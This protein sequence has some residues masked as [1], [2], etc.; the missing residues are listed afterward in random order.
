MQS[1]LFFLLALTLLV[2]IHEYGHFWVA[3]RCGVKV[4]KFSVG[5][6]KPLWQK[7]GR[8][9]TL[10]VLA[11]IPLGGYVKMLD[12]REGEVPV[13]QLEQAFNR[14]SLRARIAIVSAGPIANILFAIFAYWLIFV[15]GIPGL[16]PII[17]EVTI[18]SPAE[19]AQFVSGAEI[20]TVNSYHTPTWAAV[21]K[22]LFMVAN[23]GGTADIDIDMG[24]LHQQR[25]LKVPKLDP[26]AS[27]SLLQ[28]LGILPFQPKLKPV[29]GVITK[30]G[31]ANK[32][33]LQTGDILL[34]A[35]GQLIDNWA[36]WVE[37]IR[38][39]PE[40]SLTITINRAGQ[41]L[42][43]LMTPIKTKENVGLIGA[44][45]DASKTKIPDELQAELRFGPI[46]AIWQA[47]QATWQFSSSSIKSLIGML[48]GAVSTTNLG[49]PISIAQFAGASAQ[50]GVI[51]FIGFL[52]MI[53]ISLGIL[54][55][56]PIPVL[57]GGHLM[58]FFIEGI[59]GKPLSE[60]SQLLAQKIG[61]I[62]LLALM[63]IAFFNDLSRLFG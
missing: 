53:S 48:T 39:S 35:N 29:I 55:L 45:V 43:L 31:A 3:R 24:G 19:S 37:L 27:T 57:D 11:A 56:L 26:Q 6:G 62:L 49:G 36:G 12:E 23:T 58:F 15:M 16:R 1:L 52:A 9:G 41:T 63:M 21:Q 5:F 10:F 54:N 30:G 2:V 38:A 18:G 25:V 47:I 20:K 17:D 61:I 4:L 13:E 60:Q 32:A 51:S 44:S 50:H 42:S 33:G 22:Q 40:Q 8:N 34:S 14:Q 59:R 28:Q 46:E 7:Q